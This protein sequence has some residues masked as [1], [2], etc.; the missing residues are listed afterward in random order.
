MF[1]HSLLCSATI[2]TPLPEMHLGVREDSPHKAEQ[3]FIEARKNAKLNKYI[4]AFGCYYAAAIAGHVPSMFYVGKCWE[5]GKGYGA[6]PIEAMQWYKHAA[7][8][9]HQ[10][11][12][13][14]LMLLAIKLLQGKVNHPVIES[15][16]INLIDLLSEPSKS[17]VRAEID[18]PSK[19][20]SICLQKAQEEK[21]KR[22]QL[23]TQNLFA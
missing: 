3:L 22:H 20:E 11:A 1:A 2:P 17:I 7:S 18:A 6:F 5:K 21:N 13:Y 15:T 14:R 19:F 16:N 9:G 10:E 8:L 12:A 23:R 4:E